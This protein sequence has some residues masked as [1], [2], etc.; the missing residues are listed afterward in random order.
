MLRPGGGVGLI[1][2]LRDEADPF[3]AGLSAIVGENDADWDVEAFFAEAA[4]RKALF[5]DGSR[6]SC[7]HEQLL[8]RAQLADRVASM[9]AVAML[10]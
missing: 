3:Q 7:P 10:D 5:G 4:A 1:W 9:S 6:M 8:P 2:N